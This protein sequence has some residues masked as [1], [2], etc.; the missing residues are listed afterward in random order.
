[1]NIMHVSVLTQA[2]TLNRVYTT[3]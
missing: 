1:M 3:K 2:F